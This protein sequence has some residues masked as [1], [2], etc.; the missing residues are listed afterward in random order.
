M[1]TYR[2]GYIGVQHHHRDPYFQ[3]AGELPVDITAVCEPGVRI[4]RS[5][6]APMQDRPDEVESED[7]DVAGAVEGARIYEDHER[8]MDEESLDAV[9]I[10]YSNAET[11]RIVERAIANG[12]HVIS[13][14]PI[15]REANDLVDIVSTANEAGVHVIPTFFYRANPIVEDLRSHVAGGLLGDIWSMEGRFIA[16]QL[17]YRDTSHYIYDAEQSR[18]GVL[19]WVGVHWLDM[20][21]Y[22]LDSPIVG[23]HAVT[24]PAESCDVE[25]GATMQ[26]RFGDG[27]IGTFQN[28]YYLDERGKDTHLGIYGRDAQVRTPVHHDSMTPEPT[29]PLEITSKRDGWTAAPRRTT[30]YEFAYDRFPAWGD[31]VLEF[32]ERCFDE[33]D[34]GVP[35]AR[36][37]DAVRLLRVLDAAY[38]SAES[39]EWVT[40]EQHHTG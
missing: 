32:F 9:W 13:E 29:A 24:Q 37:D 11:P 5:D 3:I 20:M 25:A 18:G 10:T 30:N 4:E 22:V 33:L 15:A 8:L 1:S 17:A 36:G 2:V 40:I 28:G 26:V 39:G 21:M 14:K 12:I 6:L 34:G 35:P 27:T 7:T 19:Q 38:E 31:Y 23:V 16:S